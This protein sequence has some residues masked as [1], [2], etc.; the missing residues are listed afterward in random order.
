MSQEVAVDALAVA[1][2]T[3][4]Q[5]ASS[6]TATASRLDGRFAEAVDVLAATSGKVVTAG[7]GKSGLVAQRLAATL[8]STGT[9]AVFLHP[10]DAAHGDA[11]ILQAG[12]TALFISKSGDTDELETLLEIVERLEVPLVAVTGR[13]ATTLGRA[14]RV[15]LETGDIAE[16]GPL[17]F[18]PTTSAT[19]FQVLGDALALA[20][21]ARRGF[22]A[23]DFAFLHP[24]GVLGRAMRLTA[25]DLMHHGKDLPRVLE[26]ATLR[27]VLVEIL[28]KG[29]GIATVLDSRGKLAGVITD[30]DLKRIVLSC[31]PGT[32][33]K[34]WERT[35]AQVMSR[36]PRNC[37]PDTSVAR[38]VRIMEEKPGGA[39]TAL[40]VADPEGVPVGVLHLHDCLRAGVRGQPRSNR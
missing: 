27:E 19:V 38:A 22:T 34:I 15:V 40:V 23:A 2:A 20:L 8:T 28:E 7:V 6:L 30:G 5:A 10:T 16:A 18:V 39:I 32:E 26:S 35:A 4:Q 14:A 17:D 33:G 12:D 31:E 24:G 11:G 13:A 9:P 21:V 3:L 25:A 29:L 37:P 36:N 1:R